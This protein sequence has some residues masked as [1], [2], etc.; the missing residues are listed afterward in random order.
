MKS[1]VKTTIIYYM[2]YIFTKDST[3]EGIYTMER[4]QKKDVMLMNQ[5]PMKMKSFPVKFFVEITIKN[6]EKK[7]VML[8]NQLLAFF[9]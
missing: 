7:N 3:G 5:R 4:T 6:T 9:I 1:F 2:S 8:M